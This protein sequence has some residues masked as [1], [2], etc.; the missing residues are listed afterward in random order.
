MLKCEIKHITIPK[1]GNEEEENEDK[2][3][4]PSLA[5]SEDVLSFTMADGATESYKSKLWA[6]LLCSE[7][8][9]TSISKSN[10]LELISSLSKKW[11]K[12]IDIEKMPW[13]S[14]PKFEKGAHSTFLKLKI[15]LNQNLLTYFAIGD[16]CFFHIQQIAANLYP[17]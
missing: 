11:Y 7:L 6:S 17:T 12:S 5:L 4:V 16:S 1:F 13:H 10:I 2:F 9:T 15:N 8:N 3:I 14:I